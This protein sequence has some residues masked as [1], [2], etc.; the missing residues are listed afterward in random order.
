MWGA[1]WT[2]RPVGDLLRAGLDADPDGLA[3]ISADTRWTWGCSMGSAVGWHGPLGL[4]LRPGDR[5]ASLMPNCPALVAHYLACFKA[6][7][8]ATPLN[9]GYMAPRSITLSRSVG[10]ERC[11]RTPNGRRISRRAS[12]RTNAAGRISYGASGERSGFRGADRRRAATRATRRS[13]PVRAGVDL[14]HVW[15]HR[16]PER[17]HP[18][19]RDARLDACDSVGR[20]RVELGDLVLAGSSLSHVGAFYVSF[21]ALSVGA[22]DDRGAH[23]RW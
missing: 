10:P 21:A 15:Q 13:P 6:G 3:L 4:G 2:G 8:V 7:L 20:A 16:A 22:G 14:L 5:V 18:H 19:P 9:F 17:G 12:S 11:S 1:R 23:V